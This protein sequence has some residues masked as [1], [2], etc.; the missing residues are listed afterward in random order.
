MV[1]ATAILSHFLTINIKGNS[2]RLKEKTK[3]G[4]REGARGGS[5]MKR[6]RGILSITVKEVNY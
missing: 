6:G 4:A 1:I 3:A 2:Y 5:G